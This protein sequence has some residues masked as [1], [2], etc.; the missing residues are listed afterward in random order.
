MS[1]FFDTSLSLFSAGFPRFLSFFSF[2]IK[3]LPQGR[4][5]KISYLC[6]QQHGDPFRWSTSAVGFCVPPSQRYLMNIQVTTYLL[7]PLPALVPDMVL[8][9]ILLF[10]L[11]TCRG[12]GS[13]SFSLFWSCTPSLCA[14]THWANLL[15]V[16]ARLC[17][18]FCPCG[19]QCSERLGS[20]SLPTGA[21]YLEDR[22]LRV[23]MQGQSL[24]S[25]GI[26][27]NVVKPTSPRRLEKACFPYSPNAMAKTSWSLPTWCV[28]NGNS[29]FGNSPPPPH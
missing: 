29:F 21:V 10:P 15:L 8:L 11:T 13:G 7:F 17:P 22:G 19:W 3:K 2:L 27:R 14:I 9:C 20:L 24:R 4:Q 28:K 18:V 16:D 6:L 5:R 26:L 1:I 25:F 12:G 23:E